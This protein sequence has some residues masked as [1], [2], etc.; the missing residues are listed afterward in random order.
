[1]DKKHSADY[2]KQYEARDANLTARSVFMD[3]FLEILE[4]VDFA[5]TQGATHCFIEGRITPLVQDMLEEKG[6][7][8]DKMEKSTQVTWRKASY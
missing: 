4:E 5:A 2:L 8:I 7:E 1:M 6:F 3:E